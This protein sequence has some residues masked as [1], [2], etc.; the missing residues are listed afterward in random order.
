MIDLAFH[1]VG[2]V[3]PDVGAAAALYRALGYVTS[4]TFHDPVQRAA[5][6]LATR[7]GEPMI[8]LIAPDDPASPCAGWLK[9]I[10]AGAYHTCYEV[11]ALEPAIEALVAL[12]LAAISTPAQAVAFGGRR[13]VFLFSALTGLVELVERD[14]ATP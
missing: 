14:P 5:I 1:H 7:P 8:E 9:R 13:V 10:R 2:V 3:T 11:P 4:E 12:E 6:V